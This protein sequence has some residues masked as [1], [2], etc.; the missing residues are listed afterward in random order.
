MRGTEALSGLARVFFYGGARALLVA[1]WA[2]GSDAAV[3][4]TT[5]AF[6]ELKEH[7]EIG[8]DEAF[9]MSMKGSDREGR[10][11]RGASQGMDAFRH[12][13]RS[14]SIQ[15]ESFLLWLK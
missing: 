8:R 13:R 11:C 12:R 15:V 7:P 1:H 4:L 14:R 6:A 2:V 9:R 10:L 3:K 5:Q